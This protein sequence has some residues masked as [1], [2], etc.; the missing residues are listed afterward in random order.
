MPKLEEIT[1]EELDSM[2][3]ALERYKK[4]NQKFRE[5]RDE[6]KAAAE[7][8]EAAEKF[9]TRTIAAEAKLALK[10]LGLNEPDRI[11]KYLDTS[12]VSFNDDGELTVLDESIDNVKKDFPELFDV[13]RRVGGKA[14]GAANSPSNV[15]KSA[16]QMQADLVLGR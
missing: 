1:Q 5:Q 15:K 16:S 6:Y 11:V 2:S 8:G 14:D 3:A 10:G 13:K 9:K 12:N 7:S 4:E